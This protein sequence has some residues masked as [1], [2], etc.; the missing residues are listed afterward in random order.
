MLAALVRDIDLL[1]YPLV[2]T[3]KIDGIRCFIHESLG[4]VSRTFKP[5]PNDW[6][7]GQLSGLPPGLDGELIVPDADFNDT[8]S[9]VM[10][11][12]GIPEFKYL[13]FDYCPSGWDFLAHVQRM[14]MIPAGLPE[15][16]EVLRG[17]TVRDSLELT[18][19]ETSCLEGNFEGVCL[20]DPLGHYKSG[21]G[22]V[23][24]RTLMKLKRFHDSEATILGFVELQHNQNEAVVSELG[25][26]KRSKQSAN[27][28]LGQMLGALKVRDVVSGVEFEIGSGF[29]TAERIDIW[30]NRS[31]FLN[32]ILTY[33]YQLYGMKD[34][35]RCP[36]FKA[37]RY[38]V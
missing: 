12:D 20:R 31:M 14:S 27:L 34:K 10:S 23:R 19:Y 7:R 22:T 33:K 13:V 35:P 3:P 36:V 9:A 17:L 1:S 25:L 28:T 2:A 37:F 8:Q 26:L 11:Y 32:R 30:N 18:D 29:T 15:W 16:V 6:I 24:D 38:D 4:P 5:I 21:R